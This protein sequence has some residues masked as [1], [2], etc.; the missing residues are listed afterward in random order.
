MSVETSLP[1]FVRSRLPTDGAMGALKRKRP[2]LYWLTLC[3]GGT[4]FTG[5]L[6]AT[7]YAILLFPL[8][9]ARAILAASTG[10]AIETGAWIVLMAAVGVLFVGVVYLAMRWVRQFANPGVEE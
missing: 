10:T 8:V 7:V 5:I 3:V 1:P 9:A 2:S 4:A 6:L